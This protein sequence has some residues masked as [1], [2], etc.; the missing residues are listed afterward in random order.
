MQHHILVIDDDD[1][2][3]LTVKRMVERTR[4]EIQVTTATT[5]RAG[6]D[7]ARQVGEQL[8]LIVLDVHLPDMDGR[9][10]AAELRR[11]LPDTALLPL[12]GNEL[13]V[14]ELL[15]LG[16]EQPLIKPYP[17]RALPQCIVEALEQAQKQR[18][19]N[20]TVS[21]DSA[22]A[23]RQQCTTSTPNSPVASA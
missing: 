21:E 18:H 17:L 9:L 23:K 22:N 2:V 16:C 20:L 12:T 19:T 8:R 10:L 14:T 13:A 15:A 5:A 11:L 3:C 7:I 6:L 4:P 1:L